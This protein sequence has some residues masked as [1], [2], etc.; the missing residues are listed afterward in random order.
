[1]HRPTTARSL[2]GARSCSDRSGT[3]ESSG[4]TPSRISSASCIVCPASLPLLVTR[5]TRPAN[6]AS[7]PPDTVK[8]QE[9]QKPGLSQRNDQ[10]FGLPPSVEPAV[11]KL[12]KQLSE[13]EK[14]RY[15]MRECSK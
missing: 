10:L 15:D 5:A 14:K 11:P 3:P 13:F 9:N 1:M 4:R 7:L 6:A 12:R 2:V 8:P